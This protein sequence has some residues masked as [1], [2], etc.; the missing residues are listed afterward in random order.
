VKPFPIH[1]EQTV[2]ICFQKVYV[3]NLDIP[4]VTNK[5]RLVQKKELCLNAELFNQLIAYD[6]SDYMLKTVFVGQ[7]LSFRSSTS[8][9]LDREFDKKC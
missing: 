1:D 4:S 7:L 6:L 5:I 9:S 8:L 3:L 2:I